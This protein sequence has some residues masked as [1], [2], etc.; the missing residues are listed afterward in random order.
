[1]FRKVIPLFLALVLAL[2][3]CGPEPGEN[4]KLEEIASS[5]EMSTTDKFHAFNREMIPVLKDA[6]SKQSD[7]ECMGVLKQFTE[8]NK[9]S[10]DK[11]SGEFKGY[12]GAMSQTEK[13]SFGFSM[14]MQ[15]YT[16]EMMTIYQQL[17]VRMQK[18]P[19]LKKEVE[20]LMK[21]SGGM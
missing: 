8:A 7:E 20:A 12:F 21:T 16:K 10:L 15:S 13:M 17:D 14:M 18:N 11:L 5:T 4:P 6:C 19:E 9:E 3:A 2:P 1:M